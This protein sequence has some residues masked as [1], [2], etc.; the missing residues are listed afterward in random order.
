VRVEQ[1]PGADRQRTERHRPDPHAH[2]LVDGVSERVAHPTHLPP[3]PFAHLDL[4]P[5]LGGAAFE[6]PH[7]TRRRSPVLQAHAAA[8]LEQRF[9][10][11]YAL[12][13]HVID[14]RH[15]VPRMLEARRQLPVV[16]EQH[17]AGAL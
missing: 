14:A 9:A 5:G 8:E 2:Q 1:A 6:H 13:L 3:P 15:A 16:G 4:Q 12:H 11:R 17:Q 7:P 10:G